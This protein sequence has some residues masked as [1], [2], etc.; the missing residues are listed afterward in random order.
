MASAS[1]KSKAGFWLYRIS[2]V[3][4]SLKTLF[5]LSPEKVQAFLDSYQ[6]YDHDWVNEEEL[7]QKMGKNYYEQVKSK[8][9]DWYSVL[10]HLCAVG[11]VE[12]M[13]I[14]PALDL[15][16]SIIAN[17]KLLDDRYTDQNITTGANFHLNTAD[18]G[19]Q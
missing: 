16:K 7:I 13:Y 2:T 11:Q 8:I 17:Q 18:Y 12:K 6:V 14:P 19:F 15:S 3:C 10:N 9:V 4:K 5:T 1:L